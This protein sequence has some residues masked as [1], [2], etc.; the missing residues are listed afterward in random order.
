[1]TNEEASMS[2]F[3]RVRAIAMKSLS[4][5]AFSANVFLSGECRRDAEA[6]SGNDRSANSAVIP[7]RSTLL[8]QPLF[9]GKFTF[10]LGPRRFGHA[11][12]TRVAALCR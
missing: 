6:A 12:F 8:P 5:P 4:A 11:A 7:N 2:Y 9:W 1:M 10:D 3:E